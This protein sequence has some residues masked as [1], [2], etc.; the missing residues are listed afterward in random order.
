M[1]NCN[2][3]DLLYLKSVTFDS[4][5]Q[6]SSVPVTVYYEAL[7]PDSMKLFVNQLYPAMLTQNL[8]AHADLTLVPYGFATVITTSLETGLLFSFLYHCTVQLMRFIILS[9]VEVR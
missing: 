3:F 8:L 6:A 2:A 5:F 4:T 9:Q 1:Q 7:C